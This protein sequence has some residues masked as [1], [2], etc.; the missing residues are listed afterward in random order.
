VNIHNSHP[1]DAMLFGR[2]RSEMWLQGR[3]V[4]VQRAQLDRAR[5]NHWQ[6]EARAARRAIQFK[7]SN[8]GEGLLTSFALSRVNNSGHRLPKR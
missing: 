2:D 6:C 1:C 7:Y 5:S 8:H 4:Y 3:I